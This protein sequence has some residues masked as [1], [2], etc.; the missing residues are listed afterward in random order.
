MLPLFVTRSSTRSGWVFVP[1]VETWVIRTV[2]GW[3]LTPQST[4]VKRVLFPAWS[5]TRPES[6][7]GLPAPR[8]AGRVTSKAEPSICARTPSWSNEQC[9]E[10]GSS[11]VSSALSPLV[12]FEAR[13]E[14][15]TLS[16]SRLTEV[17]LNDGSQPVHE[18]SGAASKKKSRMCL[19]P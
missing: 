9:F 18:T 7:Y 4:A 15:G 8:G 13:S 19:I 10:R 11:N 6:V 12:I 5:L 16:E 2:A 1:F 3:R 17:R 14:G